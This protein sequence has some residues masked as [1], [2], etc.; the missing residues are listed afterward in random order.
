M[1]Y[2]IHNSSYRV[3][4]ALHT[5]YKTWNLI[6]YYEV[7]CTEHCSQY[8]K[9]ASYINFIPWAARCM[10]PSIDVWMNTNEGMSD[11]FLLSNAAQQGLTR[12]IS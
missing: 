6:E 1:L 11:H 9:N 2:S 7:L 5:E 10:I 3:H 8:N 12:A 4:G